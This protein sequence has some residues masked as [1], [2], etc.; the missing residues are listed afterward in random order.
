MEIK[1]SSKYDYITVTML[2]RFHFRMRF[3]LL[4]I[5]IFVVTVFMVFSFTLMAVYSYIPFNVMVTGAAF[6]LMLAAMMFTYFCMP[7]IQY[8]NDKIN[9]D[10][11]N[12][13]LF[14]QE[15]EIISKNNYQTTMSTQNY[16]AIWRIYENKNYIYMF[17]DP[18]KAEI[19]DKS[20][21]EGGTAEDLRMLLISKIGADKYKV[22]IKV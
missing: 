6:T 13:F 9:K 11:E 16:N 15:I 14:K 2:Q 8:K 1:A 20:T 21:I 7:K 3:K 10:A 18:N 17:L 4:N 22:K 12:T 19:V 5:L